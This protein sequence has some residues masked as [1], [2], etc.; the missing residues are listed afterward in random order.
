LEQG[1]P[2]QGSFC[3]YRAALFYEYLDISHLI[4]SLPNPQWQLI[5][6]IMLFDLAR[7]ALIYNEPAVRKGGWKGPDL[8]RH[9]GTLETV[10]DD[11]QAILAD[12]RVI[13]RI[14]KRRSKE[15]KE[16]GKRSLKRSYADFFGWDDRGLVAAKLVD[17]LGNENKREEGLFRSTEDGIAGFKND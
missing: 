15:Q 7:S 1:T 5:R 10:L 8:R 2:K 14:E 4:R 3:R 17:E 13:K 9:N 12:M 6:W 16:D 11:V